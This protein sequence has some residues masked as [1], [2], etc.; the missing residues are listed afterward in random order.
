M[1]LRRVP[2]EKIENFRDLGGYASSYGA[3]EFGVFYRSGSLSDATVADVDKMASLGIKTIIDLRDQKSP[4]TLKDKTKDD[5]RFVTIECSVNGNGRVPKNHADMV[6]SYI[7]ML[8]DP[9]Q[10]RIIFKTM[11]RCPKPCVLHCTAGKDRTGCFTMLL[12]LANGVPFHDVNAD[13]LL[14]LPYLTRLATETKKNCPD[15][16]KA[17]MFPSTKFLKEVLTKFNK[18]WGTVNEYLEWLGFNDDD[19]NLFDNLLGKQEKSVGAVVFHDNDILIEHMKQGHYSLPK[20]HV[21][22]SDSSEENTALREIKEETG[23]DVKLMANTGTH[24]ICFSPNP[25]VSKR[26]VFYIAD[27]ASEATKPQPEEIQDIYW[28]LPN[29]A[30]RTLSHDSDRETL[31]WACNKRAELLYGKKN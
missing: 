11:M 30:V 14:S 9:A 7:E 1:N 12:L 3:T 24:S 31:V 17:I 8:S 16:P 20:G 27:A 13:Y 29:D 18:K 4:H 5:P 2:F 26:V 21:E 6:N 25:G 28:L 22:P 10:A 23:L 15:F 19:I